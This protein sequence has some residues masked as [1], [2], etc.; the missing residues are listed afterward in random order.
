MFESD[1]IVIIG[2]GGQAKIFTEIMELLDMNLIGYV[3]SEAKGTVINGYEVL[4]DIDSF[5]NEK[6]DINASSVI[7]SI[8]DNIIR[9][10]LYSKISDLKLKNINLIHPSAIVSK[11]VFLGEGI[12]IGAGAIVNPGTTIGSYSSIGV[13]SSIGHECAINENVNIA[14]GVNIAGKVAIGNYSVVGIGSTV[15]E[16]INIGE[17]SIVSSGSTVFNDIPEGVVVFGTPAK[18][19]QKR[20][21]GKTYLR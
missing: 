11:D 13:N 15:I 6:N 10:K 8:G 12:Y 14:P 4:C 20:D 21:I 17:N 19:I 16:K 7:V 18:F 3:S 1:R 9:N 5:V 2:A